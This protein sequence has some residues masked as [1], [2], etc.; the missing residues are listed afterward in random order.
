MKETHVKKFNLKLNESGYSNHTIA[1]K[2]SSLRLYFKYLRKEGYMVIN[3]MEDIKQPNL[4]KREHLLTNE[5]FLLIEEK[6]SIDKER[7]LLLLSLAY[8]DK[9]KIS[10]IIKLKRSSFDKQ[11]GVLY[12]ENRAVALSVKTKNI[13]E[14]SQTNENN[15]LVVNQHNK[16]LSISGAYFIIKNYFESI[17]KPELRPVDLYRKK[18]LI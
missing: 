4:P 14:Q 11:Q 13:L 9:V 15:Y 3:P 6:A 10:E 16:P 12:L 2:N 5:D 17:G 18:E 8:Y 1:R 7:D